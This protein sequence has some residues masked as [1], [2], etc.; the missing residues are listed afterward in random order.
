MALTGEVTEKLTRDLDVAI[1]KTVCGQRLV[2]AELGVGAESYCEL[3]PVE[4]A[5]IAKQ[6]FRRFALLFGENVYMKGQSARLVTTLSNEDS[7]KIEG[8]IDI[9][10]DGFNIPLNNKFS[11]CY[12]DVYARASQ[13][14]LVGEERKIGSSEQSRGS[15]APEFYIPARWHDESSHISPDDERAAD[16][17]EIIDSGVEHIF[18]LNKLLE[19]KTLGR[20]AVTE[21]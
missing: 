5:S 6:L 7:V 3:D 14:G 4:R 13:L 12:F 8:I 11:Y 1:E 17:M 16:V 9:R 21:T 15:E 19:L 18:A 2:S 10:S 20:A